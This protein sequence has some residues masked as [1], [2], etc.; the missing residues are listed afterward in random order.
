[1]A[2]THKDMEVF[3]IHIE[4]QSIHI[5]DQLCRVHKTTLKIQVV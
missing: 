3:A 4:W 1:M 5:D 2:E